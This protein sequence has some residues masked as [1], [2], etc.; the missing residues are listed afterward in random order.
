LPVVVISSSRH[1]S[2]VTVV[3]TMRCGELLCRLNYGKSFQSI[4]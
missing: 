3:V 4:I 2:S 1:L